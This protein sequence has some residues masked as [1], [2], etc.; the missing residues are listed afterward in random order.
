MGHSFHVL[1]TVSDPEGLVPFYAF[2]VMPSTI[3]LHLSID[4]SGDFEMSIYIVSRVFN[5]FY[6]CPSDTL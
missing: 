4:P 6:F 3:L 2:F 1:Q 5:A